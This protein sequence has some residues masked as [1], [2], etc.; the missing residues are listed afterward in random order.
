MP[1]AKKSWGEK[2]K[3]KPPH[4]VIL[5]KD[6]AGIPKGSKLH[7]SSPVEVWAEL[8]TITPGSTMSTQA[9]RR[10]LAEKNNCEATC[11]V[12]TAIFLRIVAEHA[13]EEYTRTGS[14]RDL[15]PFWR[16]VES[17]SPMAKKLSFDPA[18]M[19]LQRQLES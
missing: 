5:E 19:D 3:A 4:H 14:T 17:N 2:M 11:P 9:F 6:F 1:R 13:W 16:V 18:W 7:I 10:R 12:S 8:K 15:A